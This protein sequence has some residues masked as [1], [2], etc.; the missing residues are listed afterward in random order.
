LLN[1]SVKVLLDAL[2][3]EDV[4]ALGLD[5]VFRDIVTNSAD[6]GLVRVVGDELGSVGLASQNE[7]RMTRHLPHA[8][9]PVRLQRRLLLAEASDSQ[10]EYIR[11]IWEVWPLVRRHTCAVSTYC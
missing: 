2:P 3:V 1:S 8:R 7:V 9:E 11:V 4:V 5:G 10:T 6:G